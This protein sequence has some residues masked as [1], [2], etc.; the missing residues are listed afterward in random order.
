[1]RIGSKS[2][3]K[4][5]VTTEMVE[6][7]SVEIAKIEDVPKPHDLIRIPILGDR[8]TTA[9]GRVK[10]ATDML[11]EAKGPKRWTWRRKALCARLLALATMAITGAVW[12]LYSL[13]TETIPSEFIDCD[14]HRDCEH[15]LCIT[16]PATSRD[17]V[18]VDADTI[19]EFAT[20]LQPAR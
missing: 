18:P 7:R 5:V 10:P 2:G 13:R 12:Y 6:I 16:R 4:F 1:M 8:A 11:G 14:H 19:T 3:S 9:F 20:P 17:L 15:C